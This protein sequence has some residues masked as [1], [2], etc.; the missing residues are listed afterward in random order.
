MYSFWKINILEFILLYR[1]VFIFLVIGV[2]FYVLFLGRWKR[3]SSFEV[4][5]D[6]FFFY[7]LL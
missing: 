5:E 4:Y 1:L 6:E 3:I 2:D 7:S